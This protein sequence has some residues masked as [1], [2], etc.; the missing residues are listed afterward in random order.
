MK[1]LCIITAV[2]AAVV[3]AIITSL[4]FIKPKA[5]FSF[6]DASYIVPYNGSD[7]VGLNTG[8]GYGLSTTQKGDTSGE[9]YTKSE[10][11]VYKNLNKLIAEMF[12]Q[13][14]ITT[15]YKNGT[16]GTTVSQ[17][18]NNKYNS[19]NDKL[20]MGYYAVQVRFDADHK[21]RQIVYVDGDSKIIEYFG[22]IILLSVG[23]GYQQVLIYF[24]T[25]T[26]DTQLT[27]YGDSPMLAWANTTKL[28][29]YIQSIS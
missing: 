17:D 2:Y 11:A 19:M 29:K 6:A 1:K 25:S 27:D 23:K 10:E 28:I 14:A 4:C 13:T 26:D 5:A 18:V 12:T 22:I 21:Q 9:Y 15:I 3:I 7:A 24:V 16:F 8:V 20:I